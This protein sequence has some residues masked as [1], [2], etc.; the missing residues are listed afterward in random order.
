MTIAICLKSFRF[1]GEPNL[2]IAPLAPKYSCFFFSWHTY[3]LSARIAM[4]PIQKIN[5]TEF[6][7]AQQLQMHGKSAGDQQTLTAEPVNCV[8]RS[9][10]TDAGSVS[11]DSSSEGLT[12]RSHSQGQGLALTFSDGQRMDI[13]VKNTFLNF[14]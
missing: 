8:S 10:S 5:I 14:V 6:H 7:K 4:A 11:A 1:Q 3:L 12:P 13:K 9:D 2:G